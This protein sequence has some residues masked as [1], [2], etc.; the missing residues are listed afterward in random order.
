MKK[1]IVSLCLALMACCLPGQMMA[2]K[3][4]NAHHE[5]SYYLKG[6][7]PE[8]NGK[9]VF[10]KEFIVA[11]MNKAELFTQTQQWMESRMKQ[12]NN[13]S[14]VA[15][16]NE[17]KG[18]IAANGE[19]YIVFT[20][21]ALAL[22]RTKVMY[23]LLADCE[24]GKVVLQIKNIRYDYPGEK[25]IYVAEEWI[26]DEYALNKDQ[27]KLV[28][29]Y[30]KWRRKTV[31]FVDDM[32]ESFQKAL[33]G[34][35]TIR[36]D[37]GKPEETRKSDAV[38]I[39]N[40]NV[41]VA[42]PVVTAPVVETEKPVE[43]VKPVVEEAKPV[44]EEAKPIVETAK[45]AEIVK[46]IAEEAKPVVETAKPVEEV[47]PVVEEKP[48]VKAEKPVVEATKPVVTAP[49]VETVKPM[50]EEAKPAAP[51]EAFPELTSDKVQ[52]SNGKL[53]IIIGEDEFN[54]TTMTANAGG[55]LSSKD[56]KKFI[57]TILTPEQ[58]YQTLQQT[59]AYMV[60]FYPNGTTSP[61]V[62]MKCKNV[63]T[64]KPGEGRANIF[65]GEITSV[66]TR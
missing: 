18:Q 45:E 57:H 13:K 59:T 49:V 34:I 61:S 7:V 40:Q 24:D 65:V 2:Q 10:S 26:T 22:D 25:E 15:Y 29:G 53:V 56:G 12:N 23:Q 46:P 6:A 43:E 48:V 36:V 64:E 33:S 28:R 16:F 1:T 50:M 30:A 60:A 9:V 44:V 8:V 38:A 14:R 39:V 32:N 37:N 41:T 17:E 66:E 55:F 35:G 5:D 58:N 63:T 47:K 11:G 31:D 42:T 3:N 19:E 21:N 20:N 51:A 52:A 54:R 4:E 27:T 62:V